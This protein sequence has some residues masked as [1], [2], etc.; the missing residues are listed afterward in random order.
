MTE[1]PAAAKWGKSM[2]LGP[3]TSQPALL[4]DFSELFRSEFGYVWNTLA[5]LGVAAR[6]LE[7]VT[8]EVFL[9]VY[10]KLGEFEAERPLRPWLF[11]FAYRAASDYRKLA[12]HRVE[13]IGIEGDAAAPESSAVEALILEEDRRLIEAA[14]QRVPIERRALLLLHEVDGFSIP[15][16]AQALGLPLNTAYSRLRLA[17]ADLGQG[18][19][20]V[21]L[22][23][24]EE[25]ANCGRAKWSLSGARAPKRLR[26][27]ARL[28]PQRRCRKAPV[29]GCRG[30]SAPPC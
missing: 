20:G 8:H 24:G 10:R 29:I 4:P 30:A 27:C 19:P 17:R 15:E 2:Q 7:D 25:H 14:L 28:A 5:R 3:N 12:R 16:V 26:F 1:A 13:L 23:R 22:G 18:G 21:A 6:D 9:R 11:S